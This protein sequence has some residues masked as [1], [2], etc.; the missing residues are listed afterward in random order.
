MKPLNHHYRGFTL[1][2]GLV[3]MLIVSFGLLSISGL[4]L[5]L[6]QSNR[7]AYLHTQATIIAHDMV[8]RMRA[9]LRG[10]EAGD[11]NQGEA[12]RHRSCHQWLGCEYQAMA[13]NDL[14]EWSGV[15]TYALTRRLPQAIAVVCLDASPNDGNPLNYHCDNSG[16]T[17]A[18]KLWWQL[19]GNQRQRLVITAQF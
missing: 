7:S 18:I 17:Y 13:E 16:D 9:N 8:E 2:E 11:Y 5:R 4:Y 10:V 19:E 15:Y 12:V 14:F 1:I 3:A 6:Q